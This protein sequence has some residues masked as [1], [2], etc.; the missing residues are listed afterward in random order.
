MMPESNHE[1]K[2]YPNREGTRRH[3]REAIRSTS[4]RKNQI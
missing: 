4:K 2:A 3:E 1:H